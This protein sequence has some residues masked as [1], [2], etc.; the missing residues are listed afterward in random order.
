MQA[1][2][3]D[4]PLKASVIYLD[5]K[6]MIATKAYI[7]YLSPGEIEGKGMFETMRIVK[8]NYFCLDEHLAR[9]KRGLALLKFRMPFTRSK[10][11]AQISAVMQ[12]NKIDDAR[13]RFSAWKEDGVLHNAVVCY[14]STKYSTSK[15]KKGFS[16]MV[17]QVVRNKTRLSHVKSIQYG[18]FKE[19]LLEARAKGFDEAILLDKEK[20]VVEGAFTNIFYVKNRVLYTPSIDCGCLNGIT[21]NVVIECARKAGIKCMTIKEGIINFIKADEV[22]LTNSA[23]GVMPL[24]KINNDVINGGRAGEMTL[25]LRELY[26][27]LQFEGSMIKK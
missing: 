25:F 17:S 5:G 8:G 10:L 19:A 22:F 11:K 14:P 7:Q 18:L 26:N 1:A 24:T 2:K 3:G 13:V 20:N 16:T 6:G 12:S 9:M 21:R 4:C 27:E 15:L 23:I